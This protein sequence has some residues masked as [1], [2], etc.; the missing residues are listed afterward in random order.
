MSSYSLRS[1]DRDS[2]FYTDGDTDFDDG[3]S[4]ATP[5]S[6][7]QRPTPS[8]D[9]IA[10]SAASFDAY[11]TH[12]SQPSRTSSSVFSQLV[13]PLSADEYAASIVPSF[14]TPPLHTAPPEL[15]T[16]HRSD[17]SR[18]LRELDEGFRL[19]FYGFGSKRTIINA[20][21]TACRRRGHVVVVNGFQPKF[22][23][24]DLISAIEKIP[25]VSALPLA[26][27]NMDAQLR[28]IAQYLGTKRA[29]PLYLFIHN[30]DAPVLRNAKTKACLAALGA[31]P[32]LRLAVSVDHLNAPLLWTSSDLTR[33]PWLWHDLTTL[34]PYDMELAFADR[35][36]LRGATASGTASAAAASGAGGGQMTE[37]AAQHVLASVTQKAKKLFVLVARHQLDALDVA[38]DAAGTDTEN[39]L[40]YDKLFNLARD[41]F[42]ATNDTALRALLGEFRDHGLVVTVGTG[43]LGASETLWV[44]LRKERLVRLVEWLQ[45][46][47]S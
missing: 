21:A 27:Q 14:Y 12:A 29:R 2:E 28:R 41:N 32:Q 31:L 9:I 43:T 36:S 5:R 6:Q 13:P 30:F 20:F 16:Q 4:N 8:A 40:A 38:G 45:S 17:A 24:K 3:L 19:I 35:S 15:A 1:D 44:P 39:A 18:F 46:Q 7:R 11:F 42:V 47:G 33:G 34:A 22:N 25:G 23:L 26:A 37:T 10:S